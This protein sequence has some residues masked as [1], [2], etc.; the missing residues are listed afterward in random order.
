MDINI[1]TARQV[2]DFLPI[3]L[4]RHEKVFVETGEFRAPVSTPEKP[5]KIRGEF[6]TPFPSE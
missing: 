6:I 1:Q 3:F 5:N 2:F 4:R